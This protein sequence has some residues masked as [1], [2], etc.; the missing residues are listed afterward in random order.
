MVAIFSGT[1]LI[2]AEATDIEGMC[3]I[4]DEELN[5]P[6][7]PIHIYDNETGEEIEW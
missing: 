2:K 1:R 6:E 4:W 7:H 3:Y 5:T